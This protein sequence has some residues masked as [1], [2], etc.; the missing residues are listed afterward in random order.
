MNFE[1]FAENLLE[2]DNRII[3]VGIVNDQYNLLHSCFREEAKLH[4]D[5]KIIR[6]FMALAPRLTMNELEKSKPN[7]GSVSSVLVRFAKRVFIFSR[8]DDYVIVVGLDV[9]VQTPLPDL[10][11]KLIKD[12]A[13]RAPD[14]PVPLQ[15]VEVSATTKSI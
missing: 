2:L 5:P 12:A 14:L 15:K 9:D 1:R 6:N 8:Y 4:S 13:G 3:F 7:L 10:V 11:A